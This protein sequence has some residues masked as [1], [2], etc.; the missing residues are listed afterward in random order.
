ME[1]SPNT[2]PNGAILH[3]GTATRLYAGDIRIHAEENPA[4]AQKDSIP[5]DQNNYAASLT[6][7][8]VIV[9]SFSDLVA[10]SQYAVNLTRGCATQ[11]TFRTH[12]EGEGNTSLC[13]F[14]A[15]LCPSFII[16]MH[17]TKI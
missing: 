12:A 3:A 17:Y 14:D 15:F 13:R 10:N 5:E 2:L 4:A 9:L 8:L 7:C 16:R 11:P 6:D 1:H